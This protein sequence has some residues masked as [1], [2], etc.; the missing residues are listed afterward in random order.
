MSLVIFG[1]FSII[2]Y[3]RFCTG[4]S[5][6][7][8]WM[9]LQNEMIC[10]N[11]AVPVNGYIVEQIDAQH[12]EHP[13]NTTL[14][15]TCN[16]EYVMYGQREIK[17]LQDGT[18]SHPSPVCLDVNMCASGET[19]GDASGDTLGGTSLPINPSTCITIETEQVTWIEADDKCTQIGGTLSERNKEE[20][21]TL[22]QN[23]DIKID[24]RYWIGGVLKKKWF[25]NNAEEL[26]YFN[27]GENEP[28]NT[29]INNKYI[30][31]HRDTSQGYKWK[32]ESGETFAKFICQFE[33]DTPCK[34]T[35]RSMPI[36]EDGMNSCIFFG[37]PYGTNFTDPVVLDPLYQGSNWLQANATCAQQRGILVRIPSAET[38]EAIV[39]KITR[40]E[41][42]DGD[43]W[44]GGN[45]NQSKHG[46]WAG[47]KSD[48]RVDQ[49]EICAGEESDIDKDIEKRCLYA[50]TSKS[51]LVKENCSA[52][53]GYLCETKVKHI[54][55]PTECP[56]PPF[57]LHSI[58]I[59]SHNVHIGG[60]VE[61]KCMPGFVISNGDTTRTCKTD[62]IWSGQEIVCVNASTVVFPHGNTT[63]H[64]RPA[65]VSTL[66]LSRFTTTASPNA[67]VI[68]QLNTLGTQRHDGDDTFPGWIIGLI[69]GCIVFLITIIILLS[70][71]G[72]IVIRRKHVKQCEGLYKTAEKTFNEANINIGME[73]MDLSLEDRGDS[74][75]E[76]SRYNSVAVRGESESDD[77]R[78]NGTPER[79][80]SLVSNE[81]YNTQR[82]QRQYSQ[83]DVKRPR[84]FSKPRST[85]KVDSA[86]SMES[87]LPNMICSCS[88]SAFDTQLAVA[89]FVN[90]LVTEGKENPV[91]V[92]DIALEMI[93]DEGTYDDDESENGEDEV[94][95]ATIDNELDSRPIS[96]VSSCVGYD[97]VGPPSSVSSYASVF[98]PDGTLRSSR[99]SEATSSIGYES[100]DSYTNCERI[101]SSLSADELS[102]S[103]ESPSNRT[104]ISTLENSYENVNFQVHPDPYQISS[105]SNRCSSESSG[106]L[107]M[108][109][110][111]TCPNLN[112][113]R[114]FSP[115]SDDVFEEFA[116]VDYANTKLNQG[117]L[118][119]NLDDSIV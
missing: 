66:T 12:L 67:T 26:T 27:W 55:K 88:D 112:D 109:R 107:K 21:V 37:G 101:Q 17:C 116:E 41:E 2:L 108:N 48:D 77:S 99:L 73:E 111:I 3:S 61:F 43:Y 52:K 98:L 59:N 106:Y 103:I 25:W 40:D 7:D 104:S 69:V 100:I 64:R 20:L 15:F 47:V 96:S 81:L 90:P 29:N 94:D 56:L 79:Q 11:P 14:T 86:S 97:T 93:P 49:S 114:C 24:S 31:L 8:T 74:F 84:V 38:Q 83:P 35:P 63:D 18:W 10:G 92:A 118:S 28:K 34:E 60:M 82:I 16:D 95:Y 102:F 30:I 89:G 119:F 33:V 1:I 51:C 87:G 110:H 65:S 80:I 113:S 70:V 115:L 39:A 50:D 45:W 46:Y 57:P 71:L 68:N 5:G 117:K 22:Q 58:I 76:P 19:S 91:D 78:C 23:T 44:I 32:D 13:L 85:S 54:P 36:V 4:E 72:I 42:L 6:E 9:Y 105:S 75:A 62:G 53:R